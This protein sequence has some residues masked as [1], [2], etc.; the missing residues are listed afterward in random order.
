MYFFNIRVVFFFHFVACFCSDKNCVVH[1]GRRAKRFGK[2]TP[3][4]KKKEKRHWTILWCD[5]RNFLSEASITLS[6]LPGSAKRERDG[7]KEE[8]IRPPLMLP[9]VDMKRRGL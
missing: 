4:I 8:R 2:V 3:T 7:E 6:V 5:G 1:E 9:V